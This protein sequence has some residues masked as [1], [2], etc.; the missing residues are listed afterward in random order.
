MND[1][2]KALFNRLKEDQGTVKDLFKLMD[3]VGDGNGSVDFEEFTL[4]SRRLGRPLNKH[5]VKEVFSEI[6]SGENM[7][8]TSLLELDENEFSRS[9][10]VLKEKQVYQAMSVLGVTPEILYSY[11]AFLMIL[12]MILLCFIFLG[13]KTF[14][15]GGAFSAVI[16]SMLPAIGAL[17]VGSN[18]NTKGKVNQKEVEK[19]CK[20]SVALIHADKN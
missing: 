5:R 11:L 16:N 15:I 9:L 6:K 12:L 7:D 14:A 3:L 17:T 19:A 2:M 20:R 4:L 13:I 1:Y 8:E 10:E 18:D